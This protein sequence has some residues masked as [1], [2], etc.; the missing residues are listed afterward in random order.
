MMNYSLNKTSDPNVL[1]GFLELPGHTMASITVQKGEPLEASAV[2]LVIPE[3]TTLRMTLSQLDR[4]IRR[5]GTGELIQD[6]LPELTP[7]ERE[8]FVTGTPLPV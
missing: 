4:V 8:Y 2:S 3:R 6:I 1:A 5:P 7:I